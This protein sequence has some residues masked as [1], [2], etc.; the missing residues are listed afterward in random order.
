VVS[1]GYYEPVGVKGEL[2]KP[3]ADDKLAGELWEWTQKE[4]SGNGI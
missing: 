3:A 4:L 1:G 2:T